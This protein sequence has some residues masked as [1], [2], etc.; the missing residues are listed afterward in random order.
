MR[1][2][3]TV[4]TT[5]RY[6]SLSETNPVQVRYKFVSDPFI[7]IIIIIIIIINVVVPPTYM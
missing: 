7:I 3:I 5:S 6:L 2:F 4:S 1:K